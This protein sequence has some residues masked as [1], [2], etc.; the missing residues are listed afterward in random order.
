MSSIHSYLGIVAGIVTLLGFPPYIRSILQHKTK[1]HRATYGIWS[2]VGI[3]TAAGYIASGAR[4]TIWVGVIYA[5][6]T[7][8][9]FLMSFKYG[10]GGI[11]KLDIICLIG[12]L[13]GI[14]LW[15]STK[16]PLTALYIGV[17]IEF[18]GT[19]PTFKKAY[20]QPET[21]DTLAWVID[22]I[23]AFINLFALTSFS[24][25]LLIYP[26][27]NIIGGTAVTILLLR[28]HGKKLATA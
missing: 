18:L 13:I 20:F 11:A 22:N 12:A 26:L 15:I 1:P 4:T 21:E 16:N 7:T 14:I 2:V 24:L 23:G 25:H 27:W 17:A 9:I 5:I 28:P 10:V 19:V 3:V 6:L 8:V